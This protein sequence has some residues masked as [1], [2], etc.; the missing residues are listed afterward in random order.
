MNAQI[1]L[2]LKQFFSGIILILFS[3]AAI[4]ALFFLFGMNIWGNDGSV[5]V[6]TILSENSNLEF[7]TGS[8]SSL[9][10]AMTATPRTRQ[11]ETLPFTNESLLG[12][13]QQEVKKANSQLNLQV[14]MVEIT[15]MGVR[16]IGSL[17]GN[18]LFG[19][20]EIVGLPIVNDGKLVF[21]VE[22]LSLE[23]QPLPEFISAVIEAE[24]EQVFKEWL[25]GYE[26]LGIKLGEGK[27]DLTVV[28][29]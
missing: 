10:K 8:S 25:W 28:E 18:G 22:E 17:E 27:I 20:V 11:E 1:S 16:L 4:C 12:K 21:Q 26:V 6:A 23:G 2:T 7:T 15:E 3:T 24:I 9:P 14:G 29:W 13:L 19:T 5:K